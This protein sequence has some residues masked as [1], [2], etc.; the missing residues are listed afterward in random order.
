MQSSGSRG[1][2]GSSHLPAVGGGGG[3]DARTGCGEG[4]PRVNP[5]TG[6]AHPDGENLGGTDHGGV[7]AATDITPARGGSSNDACGMEFKWAAEI[8]EGVCAA[9]DTAGWENP[10]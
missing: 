7:K 3:A 4:S 10:S 8:E 6:I 1:L 5:G 9:A 2:Q